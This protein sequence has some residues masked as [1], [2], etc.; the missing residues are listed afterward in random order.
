MEEKVGH[1]AFIGG[2]VIAI[3]LGL[4]SS[5][6]QG[7]EAWLTSLLVLSGLVVG[8]INVAGKETKEFLLVATVLIIAA[9]MGGA[10]DTLNEVQFVG[11]YLSS[12][13]VQLLAFVVPATIV[14][15]LK[16]IWALGKIQ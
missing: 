8:F 7:A 1:Y 11:P 3:L 13:F 6:L 10:S 12:I 15:A 14:V 5:A 16:E 2:A 9:S 4:F